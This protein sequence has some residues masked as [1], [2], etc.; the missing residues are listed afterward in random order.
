MSVSL[1]QQIEEVDRE[2]A[3]RA[4]VYPRLVGQG[5]LRQ[6]VAD[7]HVKRMQAVK[8]TLEWLRDNEAAVRAAVGRDKA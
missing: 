8:A 6:S 4:R 5:K 1:N 7:Y 2:L 3:Q